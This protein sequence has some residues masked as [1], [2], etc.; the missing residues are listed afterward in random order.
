MPEQQ[1]NSVLGVELAADET[2]LIPQDELEN[3]TSYLFR[4]KAVRRYQIVDSDNPG[5]PFDFRDFE[6][7]IEGPDADERRARFYEI[8]RQLPRQEAIHIVEVNELAAAAAEKSMDNGVIRGAMEA[9]DILTAKDH[10]RIQQQAME[11][12]N[13]AAAAGKPT[14][15]ATGGF[16]IPTMAD[17]TGKTK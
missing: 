11:A 17:L 5:R 13:R 8:V 15:P 16:K 10:Q 2:S 6:M 9:K 7:R 4:H 12:R 14:V 3:T 1:G